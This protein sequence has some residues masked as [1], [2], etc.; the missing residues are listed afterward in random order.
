MCRQ[1][2]AL[3]MIKTQADCGGLSSAHTKLIEAQISDYKAM[4][5]RMAAVE[6][7]VEGLDKKVDTLD[8]KMNIINDKLEN[9]AA[10]LNKTVSPWA[11]F[12][13]LIS[14]KFILFV[15]LIV[16]SVAVGIPL[17]EIVSAFVKV[18]I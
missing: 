11:S 14:N 2:V 10:T 12:K 16:L 7:K 9:I 15:L 3:D 13:E 5:K 8:H 1:E 17:S 18:N 4:D 6:Q